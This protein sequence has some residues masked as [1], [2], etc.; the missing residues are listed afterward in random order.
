MGNLGEVN[1]VFLHHPAHHFVVDLLARMVHASGRFNCSGH[2]QQFFPE[3]GFRDFEIEL[4]LVLV[5][6]EEP[7]L[8]LEF[9]SDDLVV[10]LGFDIGWSDGTLANTL[11]IGSTG[12]LRCG[13]GG[14]R[15]K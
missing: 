12:C 4:A 14:L 9:G 13:S 10:G 5:D 11:A 8:C 3:I 1:L 7:R 6:L 15:E 2:Q